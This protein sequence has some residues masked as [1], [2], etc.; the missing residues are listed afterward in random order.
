MGQKARGINDD[1][2]IRGG[3]FITRFS[4]PYLLLMRDYE[5]NSALGRE[6]DEF[7]DV[8]VDEGCYVW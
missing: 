7:V 8:G 5:I 4:R 2:P 3:H 1:S 6:S